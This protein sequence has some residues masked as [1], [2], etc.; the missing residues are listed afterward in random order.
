ML[1]EIN[2]DTLGEALSVAAKVAA[3]KTASPATS[4]VLLQV[5]SNDLQVTTTNI[6]L[7]LTAKVPCSVSE[8]GSLL[9]D[10]SKLLGLVKTYSGE[11][12]LILK[13]NKDAISI[14]HG[15]TKTHN[16]S[17]LPVANFPQISV[18]K[19]ETMFSVKSS[20]FL[21][22]LKRVRY[23]VTSLEDRPQLE[24]VHLSVNKGILTLVATDALRAC[25]VSHQLEGNNNT[26]VVFTIP[27]LTLNHLDSILQLSEEVSFGLSSGK[28]YF[29]CGNFILVSSVIAQKFPDI[30]P[31]FFEG[32]SVSVNK[33][34]L[35]KALTRAS[36]LADR[37][38]L[39]NQFNFSEGKLTIVVD[40]EL[41]S[42][43]ETLDIENTEVFSTYLK[44]KQV[45]DFLVSIDSETIDIIYNDTKSKFNLIENGGYNAKYFI[46]QVSIK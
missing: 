18:E 22:L 9:I 21:A 16:V 25:K 44:I 43:D 34:Q 37:L 31:L 46:N 27:K 5:G 2:P 36:I 10:S 41:G 26:E 13:S 3:T 4:C 24:G 29:E 40:D 12:S 6:F 17:G 45:L 8:A 15:K 42:S 33:K 35:I 1:V 11:D 28:C 38:A 23:I 14:K 19:P 7:S 30:S 20:I 32:S 39:I